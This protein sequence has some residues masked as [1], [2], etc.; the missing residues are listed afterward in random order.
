MKMDNLVRTYGKVVNTWMAYNEEL[1]RYVITQVEIE[2]REYSLIDGHMVK[3]GT[4]DFSREREK[5]IRRAEIWTWDGLKYNKG[6][7]RWWYFEGFINYDKT[8]TKEIKKLLA[9]K[10]PKAKE[11]Q[12]RKF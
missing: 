2:Y 4:E 8:H 6:G 10:Y 7:H 5:N 1:G 11:I 3:R 9:F 12:L